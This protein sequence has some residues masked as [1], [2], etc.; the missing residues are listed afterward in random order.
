MGRKRTSKTRS[1]S[2]GM[3]YLKPK[4][5]TRTSIRPWAEPL[6]ANRRRSSP[7]SLAVDRLE[8]SMT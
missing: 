3:P 5:L 2:M 1:A 7:F 6:L 8:V 4:E